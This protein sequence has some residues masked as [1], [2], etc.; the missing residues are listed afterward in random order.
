MESC[1]QTHRK[2]FIS[3]EMRHHVK[4]TDGRACTDFRKTIE[5]MVEF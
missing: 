4:F 2:P 1:T 5:R 3:P